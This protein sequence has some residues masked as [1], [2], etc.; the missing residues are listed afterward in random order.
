MDVIA[1]HCVDAACELTHH[2]GLRHHYEG[3]GG[4]SIGIDCSV[5]DLDL[6]IRNFLQV[7]DVICWKFEHHLPALVHG[8]L[9]CLDVPQN[10][11]TEVALE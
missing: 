9:L 10:Q 3:N 4:V 6:E 5:I 1:Q 2:V 11:T 7:E 8:L